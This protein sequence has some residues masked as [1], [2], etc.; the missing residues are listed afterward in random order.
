MPQNI[1]VTQECVRPL[2]VP[3]RAIY[4][5]WSY[6]YCYRQE[7]NSIDQHRQQNAICKPLTIRG[8][9]QFLTRS[10]HA[11]VLIMISLQTFSVVLMAQVM[12]F[13]YKPADA[14]YAPFLSVSTC[15]SAKLLLTISFSVQ[16][17]HIDIPHI[18]VLR[19][20]GSL[21][22]VTTPMFSYVNISLVVAGTPLWNRR[23][24]SQSPLFL[25]GLVSTTAGRG[26]TN[27]TRAQVTV[28]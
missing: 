18:C 10:A 17:Y 2:Q 3:S 14:I 4:A 28:Q 1:T 8:S 13:P 11:S 27:I 22:F 25:T 24:C 21:V 15:C 20:N 12:T 19:K 23:V 9:L 6:L 16:S 7:S 5:S 26:M